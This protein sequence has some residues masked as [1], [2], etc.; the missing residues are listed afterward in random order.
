[1]SSNKD[2]DQ[3]SLDLHKKHRGKIEIKS[4][5]PLETKDDLSIAYTPGVAKPCLE[6]ERDEKLSMV[7]TNRGNTIAVVTDGTAVLGLGNIGAAAALP[8]MEG[9][10]ILFKEFADIDAIPICL[11]SKDKDEIVRI[12]KAMEP[13]FGAINLEDINAPNCFYIENEL[14]KIS[15]IPIFHDDQHG[16]AVVTLAA[17]INSLKIVNKKMEDIKVVIN[18]AGAAGMAIAKILL[19]L[20]VKDIIM[21][22]RSGIIYKGRYEG[23]NSYKEA[24]AERTN[25]EGLKGLLKRAVIG[26]DVFIGVSKAGA[27]TQEMVKTMNRDSI[28]FAM[29]NPIPEIMPELAKAS[30]ARI[31]STGRSDFPNQVNNVLAFPGILRGALDVQARDINEAMKIAAAE[32][33]ASLVSND[34]LNENYVIPSPFNK[35]VAKKVAEKVAKAAKDTG[36]ARI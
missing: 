9:K 31:V 2:Y 6:I 33:I 1:M 29:A 4:K 13:T 36:V 22:D 20:K 24:I 8:V 21:C 11:D 10:A 32:A 27:L 26:A 28:I 30:G 5:V 23:M 19:D 3:L 35:D 18:G 34:E 12:V 16:T 7:Y 15:N 17:L 25:N 14:K